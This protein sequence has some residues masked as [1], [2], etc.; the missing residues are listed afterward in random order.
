MIKFNFLETNSISIVRVMSKDSALNYF[1]F[2]ISLMMEMEFVSKML[3]FIIHRMW[4][5]A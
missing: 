2:H 5:A 4:L 3:D 1:C